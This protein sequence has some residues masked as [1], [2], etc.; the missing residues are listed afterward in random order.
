MS[1]LD[2]RNAY[3]DPRAR[4]IALDMFDARKRLA[5]LESRDGG[6]RCNP[7][8]FAR[9]PDRLAYR[10]AEIVMMEARL[11]ARLN[12]LATATRR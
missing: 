12:E 10:R 9:M 1:R 6:I 11:N 8:R 5:R 7:G 2:I 3:A 4:R